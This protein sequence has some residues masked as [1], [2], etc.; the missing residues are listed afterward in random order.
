MSDPAGQVPA[1]PIA[2][3][4]ASFAHWVAHHTGAIALAL[5]VMLATGFG[6]LAWRLSQGPL[7]SPFLAHWLEQAVS[8][9][10]RP[11]VV[12]VGAA[13]LAWNGFTDGVDSPLV[14]RVT[15]LTAT[16]AAGRTVMSVPSAQA[17]LSVPQLLLGRLRPTEV[18]IDRPELRIRHAADGAISLDLGGPPAAPNTDVAANPGNS[19]LAEMA[20]PART[21]R[22]PAARPAAAP[23][24]RLSHLRRLLIT[25]AHVTVAD[26]RL[27]VTWQAAR[28]TIDMRRQ[29]S[30]A[31]VGTADALLALG[32][33]QAR[34]T[35][36]ADLAAGATETRFTA[37]L[38]DITPAALANE[39]PALHRL[40][41][42]DAPVT[43]T[44]SGTLGPGLELREG[45][46]DARV[47]AGLLRLGGDPIRLHGLHLVVSGSQT[48]PV[49]DELRLSVAA[50][51]AAT[52]TVIA[53]TGSAMR[54]DTG[55]RSDLSLTIDQMAFADLSALWPP[56]QTSGART[57]L[58]QNLTA[59]TAHDGRVH[60]GL[61]APP[62]LSDITLASATGTL[63][64]EDATVHWLRPVPPAE[65]VNATLRILDPDTLDIE[66]TGGRQHSSLPATAAARPPSGLELRHGGMRI[67]GIVHPHQFGVIDTDLA[68]SLPEL[69]ALL[70][71]KRL[72]LLDKHPVA[73][74]DPQGQATVKLNVR[75]P[76]EDRVTIDD[77]AIRVAA[78]LDAVHL[79]G[80]AAGRDL[81]QGVLDI[82]ANN[83]GMTVQGHAQVAGFDS[84]LGMEMDFKSGPPSQITQ[85]VT[86]TGRARAAQLAR[87]GLDAGT[88]LAGTVGLQVTYQQRRD[89][90]GDLSLA[91][92]MTDAALT[93]LILDWR[94]PAGSPAHAAFHALLD[95]DRL[96]GVD[97]LSVK[98]EGLSAEGRAEYADGKPAVLRL[99]HMV[100][101]RSDASGSIRFAAQPGEPIRIDMT[102]RQVDLSAR[103]S[104]H[105][106]PRAPPPDAPAKVDA[107]T[108]YV[109]DAHF[110]RALMGRGQTVSALT[111][112]AENDG[113][114]FQRARLDGR[115]DPGAAFRFDI[116]PERGGRRLS[117]TSADAGQLLRALDIMDG[118]EG[119]RLSINARF[120]DTQPGRPL[121]GML[122][123][124]DFRLRNVP[125]MA[126]LLQGLTLYG[127]VT[128]VNGPGL[129]FGRMEA[130]FSLSNDVLSLGESRMFNAA[131]GLTAR[132][133]I[134]INADSAELTGTIVP[135]YFFNSLLGRVP[136]VGQ[137]F[138]PERGSGLFAANYSVR[139]RLADPTVSINPLS[140]LT[141]GF[142]RNVF[143][144]F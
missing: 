25:D 144:M 5:V 136:L 114:L 93:A 141:P 67:T 61:T 134:D 82:T 129:E 70:R 28:A 63:Q 106:S 3:R 133:T 91:V 30:G 32:S 47:G 100:L 76:L 68:G 86:A 45:R 117:A 95:H 23:L 22:T 27:G 89:S 51:P 92:D 109:I 94:K 12:H 38:D 139:G 140:A 55:W 39:A 52:P 110:A 120:A 98:A 58:T 40:D 8:A 72:H 54:D 130:P 46:L 112:H 49:L 138:S 90:Q 81:D 31:V 84:Q 65:H 116:T 41:A 43:L 57:W 13:S 111:L 101:G 48:H 1:R 125:F 11:T 14:I 115:A 142:L 37:K 9:D 33:Q 108:P 24:E 74:K 102:G 42:L 135:A 60:V 77:I 7:P 69:V 123:V 126:R 29:A 19:L 34:L 66:F 79:A 127:L 35:L 113:R 75:L 104:H 121:G 16:D 26:Q 2:W 73:V 105:E 132:G 64:A 59:G 137:L 36:R 17:A 71:E 118:M 21:D 53:A 85:K 83:D 88:V 143:G 15:D 4:I 99:D 87:I 50:D 107:G 20:Q 78:H 124:R 18:T 119:G 56:I 103:F 80:V 128:L 96:V 131:L 62:D 6:A 97:H 10:H 44:A 122:T